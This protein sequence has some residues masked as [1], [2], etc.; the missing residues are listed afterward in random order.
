[1]KVKGNLAT[2]STTQR[3][4]THTNTHLALAAING[5]QVL[6]EL[7]AQ[8]EVHV[9][10]LEG[11]D[12][13]DGHVSIAGVMLDLLGGSQHTHHLPQSKVHI[14]STQQIEGRSSLSVCVCVCVCV[15]RETER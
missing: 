7:L 10:V 8:V 13:F 1:M 11:G 3:Q 14:W 15:T 9:K 12:G 5:T 6:C 2:S 4:N